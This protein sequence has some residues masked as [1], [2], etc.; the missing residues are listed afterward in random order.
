M[1]SVKAASYLKRNLSLF[2]SVL[3]GLYIES[4]HCVVQHHN[5]EVTLVP[6]EGAM[7]SVNN[8][9]VHEPTKLS[10]GLYACV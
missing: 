8:S 9:R 5:G 4:E 2:V 10:Q 7:C 1:C 3:V 6:L